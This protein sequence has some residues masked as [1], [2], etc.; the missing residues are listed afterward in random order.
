M[1]AQ[2]WSSVG[3]ACQHP[4]PQQVCPLLT[5]EAVGLT[6]V[7]THSQLP[8]SCPQFFCHLPSAPTSCSPASVL[9]RSEG[10]SPLLLL[11]SNTTGVVQEGTHHTT[12]QQ[13]PPTA[14][15]GCERMHR[16]FLD[17]LRKWSHSSPRCLS[18]GG[19]R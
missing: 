13:A 17:W 16:P 9:P 7:L 8:S 5:E 11:L 2:A 1:K 12:Q 10:M 14:K 6:S 19:L 3:P 4:A 15:Q 18:I